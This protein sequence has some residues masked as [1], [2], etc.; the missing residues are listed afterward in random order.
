MI[1]CSDPDYNLQTGGHCRVPLLFVNQ[2]SLLKYNRS[3]SWK[4][5]EIESFR[6]LNKKPGRYRLVTLSLL[7]LQDLRY[8]H[9]DTVDLVRDEVNQHKVFFFLSAELK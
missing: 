1:V 3:G 2:G 6:A 5:I 8:A 9:A 7:I 4:R